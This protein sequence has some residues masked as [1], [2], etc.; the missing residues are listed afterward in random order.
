MSRIRYVALL[1]ALLLA[2]TPLA[3]LA[4]DDPKLE[5]FVSEDGL[6]TLS[7]PE[8]W[9]SFVDE[10]TPFPMVMFLNNEE[11]VER[12]TADED[13]ISGDQ[14]FLVFVL[15]TDFLAFFGVTLTEDITP[16]DLVTAVATMFFEPEPNEDGTVNEEDMAEIGEAEEV[17]LSEELVAG[18][19]AVAERTGEGTFMTFM[20]GEKLLAIVY[21]VAYPGEFTDEQAELGQVLAASVVY[22][23]SADALLA[24][25]MAPPVVEDAPEGATA[26]DYDGAALI[27]E[28]CSVCHTTAQIYNAD[29]DEAGWTA[30]VDRMIGYGAQLNSAEREAVLQ[31]LV[32]NH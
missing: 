5:E 12:I 2:I 10:E 28:R 14:A 19:V 9:S 31:Y 21:A 27:E 25:I 30:T 1:L 23:G 15:P 4:Q 18:V 3:A 24:A 13:P 26:A 32:G 16:A 20:P 22:E 6:L 17:E 8:G 11:A 29:K 7:Y